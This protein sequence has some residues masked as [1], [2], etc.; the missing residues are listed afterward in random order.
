MYAQVLLCCSH[1]E[2]PREDELFFECV[3]RL[4]VVVAKLVLGAIQGVYERY[5]DSRYVPKFAKKILQ[6]ELERR[7]R[8]RGAQA[9]QQKERRDR[10][11]EQDGRTREGVAHRFIDGRDGGEVDEVVHRS[12]T[13][14]VSPP[15]VEDESSCVLRLQRAARTRRPGRVQC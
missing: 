12:S 8:H 4:T 14:R 13:P 15:E 1:F 10:R 7:E 11:S 9:R 5:R 6:E 2:K 3:Y